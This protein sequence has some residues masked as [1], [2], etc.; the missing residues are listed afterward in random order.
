MAAP[1]D[2]D[3]DL[4]KYFIDILFAQEVPSDIP[5]DELTL[6]IDESFQ[7]YIGNDLDRTFIFNEGYYEY[8]SS[9]GEYGGI[10]IIL[11]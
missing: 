8:N 1:L 10:R 3:D 9:L 11:D 2:Y 5:I 4:E 7:V 6:A